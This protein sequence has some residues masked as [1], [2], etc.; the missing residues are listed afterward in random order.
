VLLLT[1]LVFFL[2]FS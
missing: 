1:I 2:N